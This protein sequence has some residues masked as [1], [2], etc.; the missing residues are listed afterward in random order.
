MKI[1]KLLKRYRIERGKHFRLKDHD[2][3]DTCGMGAE[4]KP[5]AKDLMAD[6]IKKLSGLQ[7]I[8]AAQ[9]RWGLL[10]ILQGMD[11]SGKD[12]TIKHVMSGANPQGV[13]VWSFKEPSAEELN[14]DYLWRTWKC[15]PER[16]QIGIFN[17][18]YYEEVLV[19]RVH[20]QVLQ[21]EKLPKASV[22]KHIW[23]ERFEDINN[24]ERYLTRNGIVVVK[25]FL[26]LSK[27]E[28][29]RRFMERLDTPGKRWKFSASDVKEREFWDAYQDAYEDAI[30]HTASEAAP[31]YVVPADNKWFA[32][33]VV[34]NAV[35]DVLD[36]LKLKYP[37]LSG[38]EK[39]ALA[40]ARRQLE[41]E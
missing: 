3:A 29:K 19:V 22:T 13:D 34:A 8:L 5:Q 31:W 6:D 39:A 24:F 32:H 40:Q 20:R 9:D 18:S 38:D 27:E 4:L 12:G 15:L 10:L 28:Q 35:V 7:E 21:N 25:F 37:K 41:N 33:L 23:R 14:H 11:A 17:R 36:G 16:G 30:R 1:D 26:H 2:P